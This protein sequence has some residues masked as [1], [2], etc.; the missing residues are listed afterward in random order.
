MIIYIYISMQNI[1][2]QQRGI[3]I[4]ITLIIISTHYVYDILLAV[5]L[6]TLLYY[7]TGSKAEK[8]LS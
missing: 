8:I 1:T 7:C 4:Y 5:A 3:S 2:S 6:V